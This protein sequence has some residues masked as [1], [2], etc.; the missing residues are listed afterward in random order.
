MDYSFLTKV[1]SNTV[2]K[3]NHALHNISEQQIFMAT[4]VHP[5]LLHDWGLYSWG[6]SYTR[7]GYWN[8]L[9][10]LLVWNAQM[11][12]TFSLP[13]YSKMHSS[14]VLTLASLNSRYTVATQ[15]SIPKGYKP[16][17]IIFISDLALCTCP[18]T[19]KTE[20]ESTKRYPIKSPTFYYMCYS[21]P[22]Y[23]HNSEK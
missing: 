16:L 7:E 10:L 5:L 9:Q 6:E 19:V 20:Q 17:E 1:Q 18:F 14:S 15:T 11:I 3:G 12:L 23:V 13:Y 4:T 21:C 2:A 8:K 22:H